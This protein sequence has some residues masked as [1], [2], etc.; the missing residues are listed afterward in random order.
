MVHMNRYFLDLWRDVVYA[1]RVLAGAPGFT[2]VGVL[3]LTLGIGVCSVFYSEMNSLVLRPLPVARHPEALVALETLSSYPYLERYRD[4]RSV[5]ASAT[6]FVGPVPFSIALDSST[7][8]KTAR[9]FGHLVSPEYFTTLGVEPALGRFFRAGVEQEGTAPV[10]VISDRL[11]RARLHADPQVIG[12]S[13]RL[14]GKSVTVIGVTPGNF[15]GVFPI[16]PADVFVPV[17]SGSAIAP[18]LGGDALHRRD[19]AL[20]RVV[21]RLAPGVQRA[22]AEAALD[23]VK[24][25]MDDEGA[26]PESERK[27]R[28]VRLLSASGTVP[29]PAEQ[30]ARTFSFMAVLM[31]LILSLACTNLANLLLARGSQ[32]RKEIAIRIAVGADRFRLVRQL[33]TESVLLALAGGAGSYVFTYWLTNLISNMR[34]PTPVA[35]E[36]NIRPD[37]SVFLV[38]LVLSGIVG[39]AFGLMPALATTRAEV[40]PALKEGGVSR[41]RGYRRFGLR[42]LLVAYQVASS[43]ML[44]LIVGYLVLGYRRTSHVDPGFEIAGLYLVELDPAHDGYTAEQS[45]RLLDMLPERIARIPAV[46][47]VTLAEAAP[48]ADFIAVPNARFSAPQPKGD[49]QVSMVR[50]RIGSGYFATLGVPL[51]RGRE[52]TRQEMHAGRA[53]EAAQ[54]AL[55]NQTGARELFGLEEPIGQRIRDLKT[56]RSYTIVG[57]TRD[58]KAGFFAS[59]PVATVF[60]PLVLDAQSSAASDIFAS[61]NTG[62]RVMVPGATIVVRGTSGFDA[63]AAVRS[64]LASIDPHLTVF[65]TRTMAEQLG[66]MNT[67]IQLSSTFYGGIGVFGLILASIGLAGVTA[68]AVAR[69]SKEIG[70]RMAL[71]ASPGQVVRLVMQEGAALVVG[72]SVLGFAGAVLISRALAAMTIELARAFGAGT[73][74]PLLLVGAPLLLAGLAMLACYLPARKATKIDPLTALRQE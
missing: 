61:F 74:D 47:R 18:E 17:T 68:Y 39:I 43:L 7:G 40:T 53:A 24:R 11:W 29:M 31:G 54:P 23:A 51:E 45:S 20:F 66:Q 55:V 14:N 65:N 57:I 63:I 36:F 32:R 5:L 50:Q 4:Q 59:K 22:G 37:L 35:F 71:G 42:N 49:V 8:M 2:A 10:A 28:Q 69:R 25:H 73:G 15:L 12:K 27:G 44:L 6:A 67:L 62:S 34:L 72:G 64:E 26:V 19:L 38:T 41:L 48:F 52:F 1:F 16:A 33:L 13:L 9:V 60:V 3:S 70:I 56:A 30:R 21:G 46:G 58:L